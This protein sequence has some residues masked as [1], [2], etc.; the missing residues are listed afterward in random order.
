MV[1]LFSRA[2]GALVVLG[3]AAIG[4]KEVA[5]TVWSWKISHE[6]KTPVPT[7]TA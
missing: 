7:I 3:L 2:V 4:F 5:T 1:S 6:S